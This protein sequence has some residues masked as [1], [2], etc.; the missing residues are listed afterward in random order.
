[1][2]YHFDFVTNS[3]IKG[4]VVAKSGENIEMQISSGGR[5]LLR[6]V[7]WHDRPDVAQAH[8]DAALRCGFLALFE[9]DQ[10]S[11]QRTI[12]VTIRGSNSGIAHTGIPVLSTSYDRFLSRF[13]SHAG[14]VARCFPSHNTT[15]RSEKD[16]SN[17]QNSPYEM[18]AIANHLYVLKEAGVLGDFA[19]FGCFKGFSSS[20]LSFACNELGI[21]MHV[22]DSFMG[23][24]PSD[25]TFYSEGDFAGTLDEVKENIRNFG[26]IDAV[27]F[28]KGYFSETVVGKNLPRL[29]SLF[30]DVDLQSSAR[31]VMSALS[32]LNVRGS[33]FSHECSARDF[34]NGNVVGG[35]VHPDDVVSPIRQAFEHEG[36]ELNGRYLIGDTG[37]FWRKETGIPVADFQETISVAKSLLS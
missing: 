9:A 30:M 5:S 35:R 13:W 28:H 33:M 37:A 11:R 4:W 24:P 32:A 15:S 2:R 31:D 16:A 1:M 7:T 19:E 3:T 10:K 17:L 36:V 6:T 23:L 34:N 22:F 21:Q 8:P 27:E 18:L 29:V 12:E 14:H 25:S 20:M 26:V